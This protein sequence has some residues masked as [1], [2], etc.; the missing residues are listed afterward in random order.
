M[1]GGGG[2]FVMPPIT[3]LFMDDT[4]VFATC[5]ALLGIGFATLAGFVAQ[6]WCTRY[7]IGRVTVFYPPTLRAGELWRLCTHVFLHSDMGHLLSNMLHILN[8]L[9]LEGVMAGSGYP[10]KYALGSY[11]IACLAAVAAAYGALVGSVKYFGAMFQGASALA[12]GLDGALLCSCALL[13]GS[14]SDPAVR[15]FFGIRCFYALIHIGIDVVQGCSAPHGTIGN[16]PHFA[17]FVAGICYLLAFRPLLGGRPMPQVPCKR[18]IFKKRECYAFV[19]PDWV[20]QADMAQSIATVVLLAG[21]SAALFNAFWRHRDV[22][23]SADGYSVFFTPPTRL[24]GQSQDVE[25]AT[26]RSRL[27]NLDQTGSAQPTVDNPQ[28]APPS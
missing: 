27:V 11:H 5:P 3:W 26:A 12:F 4:E 8:T 14:G 21:V 10:D 23:P 13:L 17:G 28:Q 18:G 16:L 6:K 1:D 15:H 2:G 22:H 24:G 20:F 7:P 19:K 25:V 9:D